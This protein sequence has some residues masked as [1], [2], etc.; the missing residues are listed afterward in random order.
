M[1]TTIAENP[2]NASIRGVTLDDATKDVNVRFDRMFGLIKTSLMLAKELGESL[3]RLKKVCKREGVFF[4]HY[5]KEN[6][7]GRSYE[8]AARYMRIA[9]YWPVIKTRCETDPEFTIEQALAM[10]RPPRAK[11]DKKDKDYRPGRAMLRASFDT[12][13]EEWTDM[14]IAWVSQEDSSGND[15][16]EACLDRLQDEYEDF[17]DNGGVV[18]MRMS[19]SHDEEDDEEDDDEVWEYFLDDPFPV[20]G[21]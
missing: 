5:V 17:L 18:E 14:F 20:A 7:H 3:M 13:L 8:S 15:R 11:E 1:T 9:R 2:V 21:E 12:H 10:L 6:Y 4:K 19:S 16:L